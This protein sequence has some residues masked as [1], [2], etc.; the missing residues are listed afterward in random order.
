[1]RHFAIVQNVLSTV[2]ILLCMAIWGL[3][4]V[5]GAALIL[6]IIEL[7]A[8][9][10]LWTQALWLGLGGAGAFYL[11]GISTFLIVGLFGVILRPRLPEARVP[12][13]SGITI[14][15]AFFSLLHR[16]AKPFLGQ[17]I[18]SW[19]GNAYYSMMGC[20]VGRE[21]QIN[22]SSINDCF[23]V[24]IGDETV[25]GGDATIN[26][27]LTEKGELVL[28]Q[29]KIGSNCV[30]GSRSTVMPGCTVGDG[31]VLASNAILTKWKEI[32]PGEVW[33]GVPAKCIRKAD[34]SKPE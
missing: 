11:W 19:V 26:G 27:H 14:R 4:T 21:A 3:A 2:S 15:W 29:V 16:L 23:M 20:K 24:S 1:M 10:S 5:P 18:P 7:T 31:A 30:I 13:K 17:V 12:L 32:P 22:S 28:A 6:R 34:G 8:D 25:V 9:D 33:G